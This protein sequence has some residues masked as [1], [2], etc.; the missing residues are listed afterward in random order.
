MKKCPYCAEEIQEEAIVCRYCG[1]D[2]ENKNETPVEV[3]APA[4][5]KKSNSN[6]LYLILVIVIVCIVGF[7]LSNAN[8]GAGTSGKT[9]APDKGSKSG[10]YSVCKQMVTDRLKAPS[11]AKFLAY[12]ER[13]VELTAGVYSVNGYVDAEN[14][15]G[16]ALRTTFYCELT[17]SGNNY[18]NLVKIEIDE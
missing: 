18:Y 16:A 3:L 1:R 11:S 14:S 5:P 2:L 6:V 13:N 17:Y 12:Q 7:A 15:F 10:A 4:E 9:P 8:N